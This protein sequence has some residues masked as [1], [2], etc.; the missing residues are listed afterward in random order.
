MILG[1]INTN[2]LGEYL[3]PITTEDE[4]VNDF[5]IW[6]NMKII[7]LIIIIS[8]IIGIILI[9][10]YKDKKSFFISIIMCALFLIMI[11][12]GLY[13]SEFDG[14]Y[15]TNVLIGE[16][17]IALAYLIFIYNVIKLIKCIKT[18]KKKNAS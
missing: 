6:N 3:E 4:F 12:K 1:A 15:A 2:N 9:S 18:D 10:V 8:I 17:G 7:T 16:I 5:F 11:R 14:K 13:P